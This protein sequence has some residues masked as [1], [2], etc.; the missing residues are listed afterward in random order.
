MRLFKLTDRSMRTHGKT[1]WTL[2]EWKE[3][4]GSGELCSAG[5]LHAYRDPYLALLMNPLHAAFDNPRIFEAEAE[6][7]FKDDNGM[8]CGV[9]RLRLIKEIDGISVSTE[10]RVEFAIR[11]ALKVY[12]N[13]G[14]VEWATRWLDGKDRGAK[15]ATEAATDAWAAVAAA[16]AA[17]V[18]EDDHVLSVI[19]EMWRKTK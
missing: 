12:K 13:E 8:K 7:E 16:R 2:G 10:E 5:W 9:T 4:D 14:F 17:M 18:T 3:T 6:G 11:I 1:Q 15:A 19:N